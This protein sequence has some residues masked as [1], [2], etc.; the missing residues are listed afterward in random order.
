MDSRRTV[1]RGEKSRCSGQGLPEAGAHL[2]L[3]RLSSPPDKLA[4]VSVRVP[5]TS[6]FTSS[7]QIK[8]AG[9]A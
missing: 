3:L 8:K 1:L 9:I 6:E 5:E 2:K 7:S 4:A